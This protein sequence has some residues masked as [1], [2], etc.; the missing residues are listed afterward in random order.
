MARLLRVLAYG[1]T[2]FIIAASLGK[3]AINIFP[4]KVNHS[5]KIGH[6]IAYSVFA[7]IW[8]FFLIK[9][10][11][12][13]INNSILFS[14]LWS[15]SFGVVMEF[16]QWVFTSYRQFDYYDMLAN[17]AGSVMGL[18]FFY[19]YFEFIQKKRV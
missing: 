10:K 3:F 9:A 17:T 16:C 5:D 1:Y 15:V 2:L 19:I 6:F 7:F 14:L 4:Q 13:K 18:L 12:V 11:G 8:A